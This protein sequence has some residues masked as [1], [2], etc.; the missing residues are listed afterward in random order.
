MYKR[1]RIALV[2]QPNSGKSTLFNQIAGFRA[3]TSNLPGTTVD[4]SITTVK[5]AGEEHEVI[6]LPGTYSLEG[7][8]PAERVAIRYLLEREVEVLINVVDAS[9]L[10]RSL[11]FTLSLMELKIPMIVVLNMMDE[12]ERKGIVIDIQ[13]LEEIL[14]V[15][16][17]PTVAVHGKGIKELFEKLDDARVP[18][19]IPLQ[20]SRLLREE[21]NKITE[22]LKERV[23]FSKFPIRFL[24]MK[25]LEG[26]TSINELVEVDKDARRMVDQARAKIMEV[27]GKDP[28][29]V[30]HTL[31]HHTALSIFEKVAQ[32]KRG[33]RKELEYKLDDILLHPVL[34]YFFLTLVFLVLFFLVFKVGAFLDDIFSYPVDYITGLIPE[35]FVKTLLGHIVGGLID[36]I[37]GGLGIVLPYF[38]PLIFVLSFLE[39]IGY[40]PRVAFLVDSFMHK[41]GLHGKSIIP[42]I[43]GYGCNVPSVTATKVIESQRDRLVT[44]LLIPFVPCSA[45]ITVILALSTLFL[46]PFVGLSIFIVNIFVIAIISAIISKF[47][48]A[49]SPGLIL[50]IPTYKLPS[51]KITFQKTWLHVKDFILFAWPILI[52]G[53]VVLATLQYFHIDNAFNYIL[54]P[55]THGLMGLD[56]RLGVT[57]IFG[58]L[59]KELTL[60]MMVQALGVPVEAVNQVLSS[61]QIFVFLIFITF[62]VPCISTLGIIWREFNLKIAGISFLLNTLVATILAILARLA[63]SI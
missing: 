25:L 31:R 22:V 42:L 40:L 59:R 56:E 60:V 23:E 6:D 61:S 50:E 39:D 36:G 46:G 1:K 20:L 2:G 14:G 48:K 11:E 52:I 18:E 26:N 49:E 9:L 37:G 45:R 43:L 10:A 57:L 44:T 19:E 30:I 5:I 51:A 33:R 62:Y 13:K 17:V 4:F 53:S 16:V 32:V 55:L 27:A 41:I 28:H 15:P 24:A 21:I 12:A 3:R 63:L 54:K 38:V 7:M 29:D 58:I 8:E 34:G 35:S 47:Y